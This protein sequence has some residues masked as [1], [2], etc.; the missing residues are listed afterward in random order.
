MAPLV[1]AHGTRVRSAMGSAS[2]SPRTPTA[3]PGEPILITAPVP[4][5]YS[6]RPPDSAS[7]T[8]LSVGPSSPDTHG[9]A[10]SS[11]LSFTAAGSSSSSASRSSSP[12]L[13]QMLLSSLLPPVPL[14]P[15]SS[16]VRA[17]VV[18][19]AGVL[20]PHHGRHAHRLGGRPLA[21]GHQAAEHPRHRPPPQLGPEMVQLSG[22]PGIR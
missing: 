5:T 19:A 8:R 3:G 12:G 18:H 21:V 4:A 14:S 15:P 22:P 16:P 6:T 13:T 1:A 9:C 11:R 2:S 17:Q 10:C 20:G 7:S